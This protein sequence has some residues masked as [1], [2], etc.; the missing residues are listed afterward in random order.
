MK[1]LHL[2]RHAKSSWD[3]PW[4]SDRERSLNKRGRCDAPRMGRALAAELAPMPVVASPARRAQLTL[5]GV[6]DGWQAMAGLAHE[7]V[8]ALYTFSADDVFELLIDCDDARESVFLIG[9]N[10]AFTELINTLDSGAALDNLPTA[11]Y[12]RL[13]LSI[14]QWRQLAPGC[15]RLDRLLLPRALSGVL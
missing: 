3:E 5:A 15:G 4:A 9:H 14:P 10:P 2:L 8:E 11:A 6:C 12:A 1:T 7:T 13:V